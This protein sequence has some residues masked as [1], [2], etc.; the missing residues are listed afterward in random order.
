MVV[1]TPVDSQMTCAP[2][3]AQGICAASLQYQVS[4]SEAVG[5]DWTSCYVLDTLGA[6][7]ALHA[8]EDLDCMA[9][10]VETILKEQTNSATVDENK[11][12]HQGVCYSKLHA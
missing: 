7:G 4:R 10:D 6:Q 2:A 8:A 11:I 3:S 12:L 1:Y 9:I 5:V